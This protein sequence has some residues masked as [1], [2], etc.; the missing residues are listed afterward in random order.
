M[1]I[2]ARQQE[3]KERVR[4]A[5]DIVRV[6]GEHLTLKAKGREYLGVCPFHDDHKPSM[7]VA[8][9]KQ[10]FKCFACGAGG[11][12]FAFI[13]KYHNMEFREALEYL[14]ERA[15]IELTPF[16]PA[17]AAEAD[18]AGPALDSPPSGVVSRADLI[19]ANASTASFF[20]ALLA[21][22]QHG[23][24]GRTVIARR[25]I[26]PEMVDSFQIGLSP[27]R[28]DGLLLTIQKHGAGET[29]AF[30]EAGLLKQRD[31]G[32]YY[33]AFRHRLMFPIHDQLGRVIAFGGRRLREEDDPKYLNSPET[34]IFQKAGTL[35]GLFQ[36]SRS[37]Q[38]A[39]TAIITEGYTDTIACHQAGFSNA[40]ATLG[41]A[42]TRQH[43]AV[44]RRLCDTVILL[45]DG[46]QAGQ[47][48]A[49]RAVEVFFAEELD[50]KIATLSRYTDAKDPDELLK[51]EGGK[52]LLQRALDSAADILEYRYDRI[53]ES[54]KGAGDAALHRA[55]QAE[56][57]RLVQLGLN[58][59]PVMWRMKIIKRVARITGLDERTVAQAVPGGR[60]GPMQ[61][62]GSPRPR[63][64]SRL[65]QAFGCLLCYP[66]LWLS[67]T[68]GQREH[69][70]PAHFQDPTLHAISDVFA[71]LVSLS[72]PPPLTRLCD[73]LEALERVETATD[74]HSRM[75][76]LTGGDAAKGLEW[77]RDCLSLLN[78]DTEPKSIQNLRADRANGLNR[79][80]LPRPAG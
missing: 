7:Q 24:P 19:R 27:D 29:R 36:A 44:L 2:T 12:V 80:A 67:L 40:V 14:A 49:D 79:R 23:E 39:R 9:A 52:E 76:R 8:P 35:Y 43:A 30:F 73:H 58:N 41:T 32:G 63:Q 31:S 42:L 18:A 47:K 71:T 64:L 10:I 33:D 65:E 11:D 4:D 57:D 45:F 5:S 74:L 78:T 54:L 28:W 22:P 55:T 61:D 34:R 6:I 72:G 13:Q 50:V 38:A 62:A 25:G 17:R 20:R 68:D 21:H 48:A 26:A 60:R 59:L 37:I 53:L 1:T 75:E 69:F 46:D 3:D 77:V 16:V 70:D 15:G 66:D 56:L 51:R